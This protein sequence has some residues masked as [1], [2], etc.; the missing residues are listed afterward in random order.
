MWGQ[1]LQAAGANID[2]I[3]VRVGP[4]DIRAIGVETLAITTPNPF[5]PLTVLDLL[6]RQIAH[7]PRLPVEQCDVIVRRGFG[8]IRNGERLTIGRPAR[9][10]LG[11]LRSIGKINRLTP[12]ARDRVKIEDFAT[13]DVLFIDDPLPVG[14]PYRVQLTVIGFC[15]LDGPP[16]RSRHLPEV[17]SSCQVGGENDLPAVW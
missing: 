1:V 15:Q 6:V 16:S 5:A 9:I 17:H 8:S 10:A 14:R 13:A 3:H 7:P 12:F 4:S 2:A 11:Y